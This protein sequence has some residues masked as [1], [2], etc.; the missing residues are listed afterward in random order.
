MSAGGSWRLSGGDNVSDSKTKKHP[1]AVS[2]QPNIARSIDLLF[3]IKADADQASEN[4]EENYLERFVKTFPSL[5]HFVVHLSCGRKFP[6]EALHLSCWSQASR[7]DDPSLSNRPGKIRPTPSSVERP[8]AELLAVVVAAI[9][10]NSLIHEWW[11]LA[12]IAPG[13]VK[14]IANC[15]A[16][17]TA[18]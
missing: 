15:D 6:I 12:P 5:E 13:L 10:S 8:L 7:Q 2:R 17:P 1:P 16:E 3:R 14:A 18:G 11:Y 9:V 4:G